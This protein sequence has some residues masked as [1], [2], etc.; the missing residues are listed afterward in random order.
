M[1]ATLNIHYDNLSRPRNA[2]LVKISLLFLQ[3]NGYETD[4][5]Q[6]PFPDLILSYEE[7][8]LAEPH[9]THFWGEFESV[10]NLNVNAQAQ[11]T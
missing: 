6:V 1:K 4:D 10:S 2:F 5:T 7:E 11:R 3:I 8:V 9:L